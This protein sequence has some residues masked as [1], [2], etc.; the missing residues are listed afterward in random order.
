MS[1]ATK[2][3]VRKGVADEREAGLRR[4][5]AAEGPEN[6]PVGG[7][8]GRADA[9]V[10]V[11]I[12]LED[13]GVEERQTNQIGQPGS[14]DAIVLGGNCLLDAP[15][16][17]AHH[18]VGPREIVV[19]DAGGHGCRRNRP[20]NPRWDVQ[21]QFHCVCERGLQAAPDRVPDFVG[22]AAGQF[23]RYEYVVVL[24]EGNDAK[25]LIALSEYR[26][27]RP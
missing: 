9:D 21:T 13:R 27:E 25:C 15:I 19:L 11:A 4:W 18:V 2:N 14:N 5:P 7:P 24:D 1:G 8:G 10:V 22:K 3:G 6:R 16:Q 20:I 26:G 23:E 12:R 17:H